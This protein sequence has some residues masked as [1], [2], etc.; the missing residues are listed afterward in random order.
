MF[1]SLVVEICGSVLCT[2]GLNE[3]VLYVGFFS[4]KVLSLWHCSGISSFVHG[5][6]VEVFVEFFCVEIGNL[7]IQLAMQ[8]CIVQFALYSL[9]SCWWMLPGF[10]WVLLNQS[11]LYP[12]MLNVTDNVWCLTAGQQLCQWF[13]DLGN[14]Q[15]HSTWYG[16]IV[17]NSWDQVNCEVFYLATVYIK[18]VWKNTSTISSNQSFEFRTIQA[19]TD[20]ES[21]LIKFGIVEL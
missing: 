11:C 16:V 5:T 4:L 12:L 9:L 21:F 10:R 6:S 15:I 18:M 2:K 7:V 17:T 20:I 1:V 13:G 19:G 14:G 3:V 8:V